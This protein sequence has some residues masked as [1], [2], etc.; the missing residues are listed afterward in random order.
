MLRNHLTF[1]ILVLPI[2]L[3][4]MAYSLILQIA[5]QL[6][7]TLAEVQLTFQ[8]FKSGEVALTRYYLIF[9]KLALLTL[10]V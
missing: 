8:A 6:S 1:L 9:M 2:S 3:V 7:L 4:L 10:E 5:P